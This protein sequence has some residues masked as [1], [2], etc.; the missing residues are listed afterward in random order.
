[1]RRTKWRCSGGRPQG[2]RGVCPR[3]GP[4]GGER[5]LGQVDAVSRTWTRFRPGKRQ[6]ERR[7]PNQEHVHPHKNTF[8]NLWARSPGPERVHLRTHAPA[9]AAASPPS[10]TQAARRR[11]PP[12]ASSTSAQVTRTSGKA[13]QTRQP[14][15]RPKSPLNPT[16]H[17]VHDKTR[18]APGRGPPTQPPREAQPGHVT[19]GHGPNNE[20]HPF[21]RRTSTV[22]T[23]NKYRSHGR[24]GSGPYQPPPCPYQ[25]RPAGQASPRPAAP[26]PSAARRRSGA[27]ARPPRTAPPP[28]PAAAGGRRPAR[29]SRPSTRAPRGG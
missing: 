25:E 10:T 21:S 16:S 4:S 20:H 9:A 28:P 24:A 6:P 11:R 8:T 2:V 1:M 15:P 22:L 17:N 23:T 29:R 13:T 7:S 27:T 18:Q 5:A 19:H 12:G 14:T 3:V 26:G